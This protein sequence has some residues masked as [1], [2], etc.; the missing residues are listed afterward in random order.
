MGYH[1]IQNFS[2]SHYLL[3][4][5]HYLVSGGFRSHYSCGAAVDLHHLPLNFPDFRVGCTHPAFSTEF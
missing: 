2:F 4:F 5:S 1:Q 3:P